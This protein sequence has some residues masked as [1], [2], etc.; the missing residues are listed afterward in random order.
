M[1]GNASSLNGFFNPSEVNGDS[2][3]KNSP[4]SPNFTKKCSIIV[5]PAPELS[6]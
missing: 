5:L 6:Q 2:E 3:W 4:H 1:S